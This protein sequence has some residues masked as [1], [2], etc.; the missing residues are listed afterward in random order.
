MTHSDRLRA[1]IS[2]PMKGLAAYREAAAQGIRDAGHQP[3]R[4]EDFPSDTA[5]PRNSCLDGVKSADVLV[6]LLFERYG[7]VTPSGKSATEEEYDEARRCHKSI[8]VFRHTG[9]SPDDAQQGFVEKVEDYVGGH[10][11]TCFH[12]PASLRDAIKR[13]MSVAKKRD[14]SRASKAATRLNAMISPPQDA[15]RNV[16][17]HS[18]WTTARDG[19]DIDVMEM[20]SQEYLR[21]I[22]RM[23][24]DNGQ[25]LLN[26][27]CKSVPKQR[28]T[29]LTLIQ[30]TDDD[31]TCPKVVL[32]I[33]K[34]WTLSIQQQVV[35]PYCDPTEYILTA[36]CLKPSD[37]RTLLARAWKFAEK[38]WNRYD[39]YR[40]HDVLFCNIILYNWQDR[41][42]TEQPT[43]RVPMSLYQNNKPLQV[44][45]QPR[46]LSRQDLEAP[47][48]EIER[49]L[50]VIE[51]RLRESN[52]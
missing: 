1:F 27:D 26:Y 33:A 47:S 18:V 39:S 45:D 36:F 6:L 24:H 49:V 46:Q 9:V 44:F 35:Q 28:A 40:R 15:D 7:F 42:F 48:G 14:M 41:L 43:N 3:I 23:A 29:E 34:D 2:S 50:K 5:S 22:Q 25:P 52:Q 38:W 4:V 17:V 13:T 10:Q 21:T 31:A 20:S 30:T 8:L 11:R 19:E 37:V 12:D 51:L 16:W 32:K